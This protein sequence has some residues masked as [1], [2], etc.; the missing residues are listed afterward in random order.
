MI[1]MD[2]K[3]LK[4][5]FLMF[6]VLILLLSGCSSGSKE[7]GNNESS[8]P[9]KGGT[10]TIPI[11]GDPIFN[12]WHPNA[13]AESNLVNRVIFSGL[14][15]PGKDLTPAPNLAKE[16]SVSKDGLVWTF[17]LRDDVKWHDGE[18][19]TAED[20][21]FTFNE[22]VLKKELGSNGAS[23]YK[24][25]DHV[26]AVD[27]YTVEFHLKNPWAALP[28]YLGFNSGILPK[29]IF[30]GKDPWNLTSFNKEKPIGTGPF[31]IGK[32]V[33]GQSVELVPNPDYFDGEPY[34]DKV[35][36]KILP[37]ANTQVVQALSGELDIFVLEDMASL[38]R[39]KK[40]GHLTIIPSDITRYFWIALNQKHEKFQ[41]VKVRQAFLHAIDR[42]AIIDTVLK[43]YGKIA[44]SAITPNLKAYYT[45]EVTKYEY[46][47]EKAK[48][49]LAEAG[50]RDTDGDGILDKDGKPFTVAFEVAKQGNLEQIAQMVQQYLKD[51]GVDIKL[52]TLEWNAMIEKH[53]IKRDFEMTLNWWSYPDDPDVFAQYHSSNAETGNNIPGY[54]DE[55]LDE[56]L[57]RG[58]KTSDQAGRVEV[59]KELQQYLSD[60]LPYLYLWYP[61]EIQVRNKKLK[62]V[63]EMYFGGT[64]HYIHEWWVGN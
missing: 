54:K 5:Y 58:Q 57:V 63:P 39:I 38:E 61:Q 45:D 56:L 52:S 43:G 46:D 24:A 49:L 11:V 28:A 13:Y 16:W 7:S 8:G 27:D 60:T 2:V 34:L 55:K 42:Q 50:W 32:Y 17:K 20:V 4:R 14:T 44:H 36:Y 48:Q 10:V 37:D 26:E 9:K 30:E 41:D 15:K 12:P 53:V 22:I 51:I 1:E 25:L 40:A 29:H 23:N 6:A 62:G 18:P 59:Y 21:A 64:L 19:F 31:K 35:V 3:P 47:P 33:S